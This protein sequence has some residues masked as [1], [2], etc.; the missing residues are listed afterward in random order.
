MKVFLFFHENLA[1]YRKEKQCVQCDA[2][3]PRVS[4]GCCCQVLTSPRMHLRPSRPVSSSSR[5]LGS[6]P[7]LQVT[8]ELSPVPPRAPDTERAQTGPLPRPS[9]PLPDDVTPMAGCLGQTDIPL[10]CASWS[11]H[12]SLYLLHTPYAHLYPGSHH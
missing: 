1:T 12:L 8:L 9:H 11:A 5:R 7:T 3:C 10:P 2:P 6:S 4:P